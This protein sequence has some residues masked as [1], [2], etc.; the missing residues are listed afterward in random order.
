MFRGVF[1]LPSYGC[2]EGSFLRLGAYSARV[3]LRLTICGIVLAALG[4]GFL[5]LPHDAHDV[6]L[7]AVTGLDA[8]EKFGLDHHALHT[9][10]AA[11]IGLLGLG[12]LGWGIRSRPD[13][14][15]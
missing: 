15:N 4:F 6:V 5:L 14:H 3:N 8:P 12:V 2:T 9:A 1:E 11:V 13:V 7:G 10:G